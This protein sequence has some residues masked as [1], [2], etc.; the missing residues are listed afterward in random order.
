MYYDIIYHD[1][2]SSYCSVLL[3]MIYTEKIKQTKI[4][5]MMTMSSALPTDY[6]TSLNCSVCASLNVHNGHPIM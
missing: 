4:E 6:N 5:W 1:I 3:T 2:M